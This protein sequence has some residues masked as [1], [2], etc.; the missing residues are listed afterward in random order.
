MIECRF[1]Q[2]CKLRLYRRMWGGR[3]AC[4]LTRATRNIG[5][6]D[7]PLDGRRR[8]G[9]AP[10]FRC[11]R[12]SEAVGAAEKCRSQPQSGRWTR[13]P[14]C[15]PSPLGCR[16][17]LRSD[18]SGPAPAREECCPRIASIRCSQALDRR[19]RGT[20]DPQSSPKF[21]RVGARSDSPADLCSLEHSI[22]PKA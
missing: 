18:E 13:L 14:T 7:F 11:S 9:A 8:A 3:R 17:P 19:G 5:R 6:L 12:R 16:A 20:S 2:R 10:I 21:D 1:C 22:R 4:H 15:G